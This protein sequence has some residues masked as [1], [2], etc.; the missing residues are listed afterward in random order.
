M[1]VLYNFNCWT[2]LTLSAWS[3]ESGTGP[4]VEVP[5]ENVQEWRTDDDAAAMRL[6]TTHPPRPPR[7]LA[8]YTPYSRLLQ[9]LVKVKKLRHRSAKLRRETLY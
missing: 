7:A 6:V 9:A 1:R 2:G 4:G 5:W 3:E 8:L